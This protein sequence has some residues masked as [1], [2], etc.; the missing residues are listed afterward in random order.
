MAN[1]ARP[2]WVD[3]MVDGRG[4]FEALSG[5]SGVDAA[6]I[7]GRLYAVVASPLD[8]GIQIIDI[9]HPADPLPTAAVVDGEAG[10]GTLAMASGVAMAEISG[11]MYA[12][13]SGWE[14][15]QVVDMSS[16]SVPHPVAAMV[17]GR[18]GFDLPAG[19]TGVDVAEVD[20]RTFVLVT[21]KV[22]GMVRAVDIT[23]PAVPVPMPVSEVRGLFEEEARLGG[24]AVVEILGRTYA[25]V[26]DG[27]RAVDITEREAGAVVVEDMTIIP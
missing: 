23:N 7:S 5:A 2:V 13:V 9:T 1:P 4:G 15:I 27:M 16:P 26:G 18:D 22:D 11:R 17:D 6:E 20:G 24:A 8:D 14:G 19:H 3:E 12:V 10:F 21:G 25:L